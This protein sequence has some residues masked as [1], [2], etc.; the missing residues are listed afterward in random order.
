MVLSVNYN[1]AVQKDLAG[2][3]ALSVSHEIVDKQVSN[4]GSHG[5]KEREVNPINSDV[6]SSLGKHYV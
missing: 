3:G 6:H 1:I 4:V 2:D 5:V